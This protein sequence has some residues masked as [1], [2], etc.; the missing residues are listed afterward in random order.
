MNG[1]VKEE[2]PDIGRGRMTRK[3]EK[4]NGRCASTMTYCSHRRTRL[5]RVALLATIFHLDT[6]ENHPKEDKLNRSRSIVVGMDG[7]WES[8]HAKVKSAVLEFL[9]IVFGWTNRNEVERMR[10]SDER[11][12]P[13][14]EN[15]STAGESRLRMDVEVKL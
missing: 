5:M 4:L 15:E 12:V 7:L 8:Q 1:Q 13:L 9:M 11:V 10:G 3:E 14:R 2:T 6:V